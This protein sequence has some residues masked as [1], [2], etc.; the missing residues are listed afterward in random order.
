MW[1]L[2]QW[3]ARCGT[4]SRIQFTRI[5]LGEDEMIGKM[6]RR[7][8][9]HLLITFYDDYTVEGFEK[10]KKKFELPADLS[11]LDS[12]TKRQMTICNLFANQ[13]LSIWEIVKLLDSSPH[14]VVPTLIENGLIKERR[15]SGGRR[16]ADSPKT[17]DSGRLSILPEDRRAKTEPAGQDQQ[18]GAPKASSTETAKSREASAS[19]LDPPPSGRRMAS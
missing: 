5:R 2:G 11:H 12:T 13:N 17:G 18:D 8:W 14:Q 9:T 19:F 7:V 16:G 1:L 6:L 4:S 3:N 15:R 10:T